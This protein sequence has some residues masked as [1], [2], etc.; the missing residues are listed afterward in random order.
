MKDLQENGKEHYSAMP[1][2]RLRREKGEGGRASPSCSEELQAL[3]NV[4]FPQFFCKKQIPRC[5][6]DD[7][8][9]NSSAISYR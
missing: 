6:R 9:I 7:N 1:K 4:L 5:A 2:R 3:R 8:R